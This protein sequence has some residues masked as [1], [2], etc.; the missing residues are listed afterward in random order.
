MPPA[1]RKADGPVVTI[2]IEPKERHDDEEDEDSY[3]D[4]D[5]LGYQGDYECTRTFSA[6]VLVDGK[7]GGSLSAMLVDRDSA[8]SMF[9]SA[10]DA[11]SAEL[12]EIGCLFFGSS[13]QVR[14]APLKS[15]ASAK[16]G[17][18]LY[19]ATFGLDA[20]HRVGGATD[21]GA[22]AIRALLSCDELAGRWS[23]AS[24]IADRTAGEALY[25]RPLTPS[26]PHT[27]T[28]L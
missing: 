28:R 6:D 27:L 18:F 26:H 16:R 24:Y 15:D 23:V 5:P 20:A 1:K 22:S 12:Q 4:D 10:C 9:H 25:T 8:R 7:K 19:I 2:R 13:G 11:E 3:G 17:G 14:Y 21:V